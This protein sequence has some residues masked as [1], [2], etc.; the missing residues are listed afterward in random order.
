MYQ[1]FDVYAQKKNVAVSSLKF[2]FEGQNLTGEMTP[3]DL[4][5][6]DNDAVE[7]SSAVPSLSLPALAALNLLGAGTA[8]AAASPSRGQV[9]GADASRAEVDAAAAQVR[10][11]PCPRPSLP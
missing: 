8:R 2:T 10:A 11:A 5:L 1:V 3:D 7:V 9:A 4:G 6:G